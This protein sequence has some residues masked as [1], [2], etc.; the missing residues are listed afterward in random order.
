MNVKYARACRREWG[1]QG[2]R[3]GQNANHEL[4][5]VCGEGE[6]EQKVVMNGTPI[7]ALLHP[8]GQRI[9]MDNVRDSITRS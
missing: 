6:I 8:D 2:Q 3:V 9:H 4:R 7:L 5:V 1:D